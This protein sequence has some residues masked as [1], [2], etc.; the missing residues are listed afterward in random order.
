[1]HGLLSEVKMTR[2]RE[3]M[4][5]SQPETMEPALRLRIQACCQLSAHKIAEAAFD[6]PTAGKSRQGEVLSGEQGG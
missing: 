1:M 6:D 5:L 3:N 2:A 4:S